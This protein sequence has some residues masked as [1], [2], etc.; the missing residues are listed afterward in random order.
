MK[1]KLILII[2][3]LFAAFLRFYKIDQIPPALS[4][5]E[6]S[7]GYDAYSVLK[8]GKDQWGETFP[9]AFKSFGE[10][11]YPFHIYASA[12]SIYFFGLNEFA[13]R[14]PSALFG[15]INIF[16]LYLLVWKLFKNK[17]IAL[18]SAFLL[19]ISPWHIQF[20]RVIWETNFALFF[21][22]LGLLLFI[23]W[24]EKVKSKYLF[25]SITLLGLGIY[26]YNAAK[27][28]IPL[29]LLILCWIHRKLFFAHKPQ[30]L[31]A[32]L[33]FFAIVLFGI[34][35]PNLSGLSRFNQFEYNQSQYDKTIIYKLIKREKPAKVEIFLR[36]YLLHFSPKYLFVSGDPNLRHSIQTLGELYFFDIIMLPLG[37]YFL[38]KKFRKLFLFI[39]LWLFI[40]PVPASIV[41]EAPHA[42]RAMFGI[43]IFQ[44]ISAVGFWGFLATIKTYRRRNMF[45]CLLGAI[46]TVS[47]IL[48]LNNYF[49]YYSISSAKSWQY[50]YKQ[51]AEVVEKQRDNYDMIVVTRYYGEP[52]EFLLFYLK[53]PPE[54]YQR[55]SVLNKEKKAGWTNVRGFDK[56][57]FPEFENG[58]IGPSEIINEY[59][60]KKILFIT[61]PGDFTIN[62]K[63]K[64]NKLSEVDF[65]NG[66]T[67]FEVIEYK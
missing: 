50:G 30:I 65:L 11:K 7:I 54:M 9:L 67:A 23:L 32:S 16:L 22:F 18:T 10:Y 31:I 20:S 64:Y 12:V 46:V 25:L 42:S 37:L 14:F 24:T 56:F 27:I 1:P 47:V 36:Q 43:G 15:V 53:Y 45:V 39:V 28:F 44:I 5:D 52:Q 13:V 57:I 8:T 55:E 40:S 51:I 49:N 66:E 48:Y 29:F 17:F 61:K 63:I 38:Y 58:S 4:W 3:L 33:I 62:L 41:N 2:I 19:A 6:V 21:F 34:F 26:T 35:Q 60:N 59:S